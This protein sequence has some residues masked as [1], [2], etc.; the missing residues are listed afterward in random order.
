[1]I[2]DDTRRALQGNAQMMQSWN[3][4]INLAAGMAVFSGLGWFV[5]HYRGEGQTGILCGAGLGLL[6]M[7]YELWKAVRYGGSATAPRAG[8]TDQD[9]K[10]VR[11]GRR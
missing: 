5:D 4:G 2:S 9:D 3:L 7:V 10:N 11:E 6:Y 1:M 8:A